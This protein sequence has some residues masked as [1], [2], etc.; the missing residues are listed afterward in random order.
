MVVR[1]LSS[2]FSLVVVGAFLLW[3]F[4]PEDEAVP[5][6][7]IFEGPIHMLDGD[8]LRAGNSPSLRLLA[9][10]AL[11]YE[12]MCE[13]DQ[14][15]LFACGAWVTDQARL[16]FNGTDAR[17][18]AETRDRYDRPLVVCHVGEID[19]ASWLVQEG[20]AQT[21]RNDPTYAEEEKGAVLTA[22]GIWA[23]NAQDPSEYRLTRIRGRDAL[24][25]NCAI[26]GNITSHGQIYHLPGQE[27]YDRTGIV[28]ATGE[29]WFC[30]EAEAIAAGW[31]PAAR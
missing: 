13:T 3:W 23:M 16:R 25:P 9:I 22:R 12:Q 14:G 26:K 18:L 2:L 19:V 30:S 1:G 27:N 5:S 20:L 8:T 24:D 28:E 7:E 21:Y 17:C 11:E 6:G 15:E 10:D 4:A 31:R 29:R